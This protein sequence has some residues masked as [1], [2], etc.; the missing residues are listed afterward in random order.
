MTPPPTSSTSTLDDTAARPA[1][2]LAHPGSA[3]H[4]LRAA[5]VSV[6]IDC[7]GPR[8]P[9][10]VHWGA[11]LGDLDDD[12]AGRTW[13]GP[14]SRPW[15]ATCPTSRS[16]RASLT[17]HVDRMDG[18]ARPARPP[19]RPGL[20]DPVRRHRTCTYDDDH[21]GTQRLVVDAR[22]DAAGLALS[23]TLELTP[24][25]V[26]RTRARSPIDHRTGR[27][28]KALHPRRSDPVAAG[29]DARR[30]AAR[31]RRAAPARAA[32]AAPAV[33]RRQL[34]AGQ[35]ARAHRVGRHHAAGRRHPRASA[36]V[37]VRSGRCTPPGAATTAPIAER[38]PNGHAVLAGGELLLPGEIILA[39]GES[40]TTPVDLRLATGSAWTPCRA[41]FH[42]VLRARPRT[43]AQPPT[44]HPE[45]LGIGVLRHGPGRADRARRGAAPR[46]A[47]NGTCWTTA[48]SS[49]AATTTPAWA[50]GRSTRTCGPQ[51]LHPLVDRVTELGMQFGLWVEPEMI[52]PDSN[53]AR[54]HPE[55]ILATGEPAAD[56]VPP[57]AGARPGPPRGVR[58]HPGPA[59]TRC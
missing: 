54:A 4:H 46:S 20:V 51:G 28:R 27:H 58:L 43:P 9:R 12:T 36:S 55:W 14:T 21:D 49:V 29:T 22:D 13:C 19:R 5:G 26:L 23:L 42:A 1:T 35:P 24:A 59:W 50:T 16:S 53:L 17:E 6:V 47:R 39:A 37:R 15:S 56:R 7:Q 8:L 34:G 44:G 31:L 52:N 40:Y 38:T 10:I 18:A 33:R 48:G 3:V 41:R 32:P 25:G 11:D 30:R 57:P 2:R 45:H